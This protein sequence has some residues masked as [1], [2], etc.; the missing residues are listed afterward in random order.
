MTS[1]N[2]FTV[3]NQKKKREIQI[4]F[5]SNMRKTFYLIG[6]LFLSLLFAN[7]VQSSPS[8]ND[9]S[10][11][12]ILDEPE[13]KIDN[14]E[15][16]YL[17]S[18]LDNNLKKEEELKKDNSNDKQQQRQQDEQQQQQEQQ[19]QDHSTNNDE[20]DE[21]E[22]EVTIEEDNQ[23]DDEIIPDKNEKEKKPFEPM[24]LS[25]LPLHLR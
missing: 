4:L 23:L 6:F 24:K 15:L 16:N 12:D 19:Q 14:P 11:F 3:S 10:E 13:I 2:S 22:E 7:Y 5:D 8:D 25:S 17:D 9:F 20:E 18:N 21:D 1:E